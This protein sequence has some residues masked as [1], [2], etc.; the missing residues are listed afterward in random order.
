M[1]IRGAV[2]DKYFYF[3]MSLLIAAVVVYGF[4]RTL[5]K[6]LIHADE[7]RPFI[8]YIH[9]SVFFGWVFFLVVQSALVRTH[10][11]NAIVR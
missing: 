6:N 4:S 10:I 3:M 1:T 7:P 2:L 9:A 8:L 5:G 11:A